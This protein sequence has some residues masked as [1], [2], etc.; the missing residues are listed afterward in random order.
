VPGSVS[1]RGQASTGTIE[2]ACMSDEVL[3]HP[4]GPVKRWEVGAAA[5]ATAVQVVL[6]LASSNDRG[7]VPGLM[8]RG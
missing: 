8:S 7:H 4:E 6:M 5:A 1:L 3:V 2:N